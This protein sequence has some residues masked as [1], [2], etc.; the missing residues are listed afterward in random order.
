MAEEAKKRGGRPVSR[1][2]GTEAA[3]K[4]HKRNGEEIDQA[5][6]DAWAAAQRRYYELRKKRAEETAGG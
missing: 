2:C 6:A 4:R 1:P 5:C 3:Y